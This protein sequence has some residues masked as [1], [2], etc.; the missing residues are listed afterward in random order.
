[1]KSSSPDQKHPRA[2]HKRGGRTRKEMG[3]IDGEKAIMRA[4]RKARKEG[5]RATTAS[6]L[7]MAAKGTPRPSGK[8]SY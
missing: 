6:P 8:T 2:Q 7:S 3:S 5:G 4:D 1:M